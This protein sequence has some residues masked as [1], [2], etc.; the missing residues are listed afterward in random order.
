LILH[1]DIVLLNHMHLLISL[2]LNN[3]IQTT[4]KGAF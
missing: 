3:D 1:R 4:S 2:N